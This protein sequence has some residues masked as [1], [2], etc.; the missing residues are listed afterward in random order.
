[1]IV[2]LFVGDNDFNQS[3][4][5]IDIKTLFSQTIV[6]GEAFTV[7]AILA[8]YVAMLLWRPEMN[9]CRKTNLSFLLEVSEGDNEYH[10]HGRHLP[11]L[12]LPH[13]RGTRGL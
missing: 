13:T 9:D 3:I 11:L 10:R 7:F 6:T 8:A 2:L 12:H 5:T 4:F 1:M